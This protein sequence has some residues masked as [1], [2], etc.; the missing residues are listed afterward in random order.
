MSERCKHGKLP[1]NPCWE[2]DEDRGEAH[3]SFAAPTG[4]AMWT[5]RQV[6]AAVNASCSCG[7]KGPNDGCCQACE[8]WHRLHGRP[9][10]TELTDRRGV[11][12]A[13]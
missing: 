3:S 4:S 11:D 5:E 13:K 9:P 7:G 8:V 6:T 12:S 1:E 2:C 10:N